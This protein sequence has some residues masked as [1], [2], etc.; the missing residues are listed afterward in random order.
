[1]KIIAQSG[2]L[3]KISA[4]ILAVGIPS[5]NAE[6]LNQL[7]KEFGTEFRDILVRTKFSAEP[8]EAIDFHIAGNKAGR[9]LLVGLGEGEATSET[10]RR[11]AGKCA[12]FANKTKADTLALSLPSLPV[13]ANTVQTIAE[14]LWLSNYRFLRYKKD[15]DEKMPTLSNAI[16]VA[17]VKSEQFEKGIR[18]AAAAVLGVT[19]TRDLANEPSNVVTPAHLKNIATQLSESSKKIEVGILEE[20]H[21]KANNF[22]A[23]LAVAKG[24]KEKPYLIHLVYKAKN[25]KLRLAVVGKGITFDSGGISLKP[26]EKME[27]MKMDMSGAAAVLGLFRALSL[28][29]LPIEIHGIIPTCENMPGGGATKPGDVVRSYDGKTIEIVNTDAE[30]RLILADAL[31]YVSKNFLPN[32]IIE[33]STLTGACMVALGEKIAGLMSSNDRLCEQLQ[34]ASKNTGEELWRMPLVE[35]YKDKLKSEIADI[36]NISDDRTA[37]V[38]MG[39]LFLNEFVPKEISFAHIDIAGPAWEN[40]GDLGYMPKG[41]TGFGVRLLLEYLKELS[42]Q[43]KK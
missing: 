19:L 36:K 39:G 26:S 4:D 11:F 35:D 3:N 34:A 15:G 21:L 25:P 31:A 1:M 22:G 12:V 16:I 30:G 10:L 33:L 42:A 41:A 18:N 20:P 24:S 7:D 14:A 23:L 2:E 29:D 43:K 6:I 27:E 9:V 28:I 17:K 40:K 13:T 37:G 38:I 32:T 5:G 8:S